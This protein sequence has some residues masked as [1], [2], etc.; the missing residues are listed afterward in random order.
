MAT[1]PKRKRSSGKTTEPKRDERIDEEVD[2]TFPASDP[3]S[4]AGGKHAVGAPPN[5]RTPQA[6][7]RKR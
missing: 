3:P 2:E 5:R 7:G 6:N 1:K 4:Y